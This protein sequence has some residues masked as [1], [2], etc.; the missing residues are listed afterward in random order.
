MVL[1]YAVS[2]EGIACG[3]TGSNLS[4][5]TSVGQVSCKLCLRSVEKAAPEP[6]RRT[7]SLAELRAAATAEKAAAATR[8]TT[9]PAPAATVRDQWCQ[10]LH[11]LPGRNRLPRGGARQVFVCR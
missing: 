5:T 1:H 3:R 2:P 4:H 6:V 8:E 9:S 11:G 7:P 10:R